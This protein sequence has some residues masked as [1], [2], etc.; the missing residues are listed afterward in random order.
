MGGWGELYPVLFWIF[1][2]FLTLL[3]PLH[4][5]LCCFC[6]FRYDDATHDAGEGR[7]DP[8]RVPRLRGRLPLLQSLPGAH[9]YI[10]RLHPALHPRARHEA[11]GVN[12]ERRRATRFPGRWTPRMH[13]HKHARSLTTHTEHHTIGSVANHRCA[14]IFRNWFPILKTKKRFRWNTNSNRWTICFQ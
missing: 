4:Y 11:Q 7:T 13:A 9:H 10:P 5:R 1:G 14:T 3:I 8:V 12:V 6:R 2:I